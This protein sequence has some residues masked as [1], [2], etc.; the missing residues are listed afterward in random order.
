MGSFRTGYS[1]D[2]PARGGLAVDATV[3]P[4]DSAISHAEL[5][6]LGRNDAYLSDEGGEWSVW[7]LDR[8]AEAA[9]DGT[10]GLAEG[11]DPGGS[12]TFAE[13][14]GGH[15]LGQLG[16]AMPNGSLLEEEWNVIA[17][18]DDENRLLEESVS[19]GKAAFSITGPESG[20]YPENFFSWWTGYDSDLDELDSAIAPHL[21]IRLDSIP[22]V[23]PLAP[24]AVVLDEDGWENGTLNASEI[25][26][27]DGG[28]DALT[29]T[30]NGSGG[31]P[32]ENITVEI[33]RTGWINITPASNWNGIQIMEL[34]V[35]DAMGS[36]A[37]HEVAVNVVPVNDPVFWHNLTVMGSGE[38][39]DLDGTGEAPTL[40]ATEDSLFTASVNVTDVDV[41]HGG[42]IYS[43][44]TDDDL[45]MFNGVGHDVI[46]FRPNNT[47]VGYRYVT[48]EVSDADFNDTVELRV[49]VQNVN[50]PPVAVVEGHDILGGE[51]VQG[52]EVELDGGES[53]D[54]DLPHGDRLLYTWRSNR[55]GILGSDLQLVHAF[56]ETGPHS[57]S[58]TVEDAEGETSRATIE[59]TVLR[60]MDGDG[61][62]DR[63]DEDVDGDGLPDTWEE[64]WGLDPGDPT[65]A[66]GDADGDGLTN[67]QEWMNGTSPNLADTDGDGM[68]DQWEVHNGLD[69]LNPLD[70]SG[71][72]DGDGLSNLEEYLEGEDPNEA[73]VTESGSEAAGTGTST[74]FLAAIVI[75]IVIIIIVVIWMVA[76]GGRPSRIRIPM[77]RV[78]DES[79]TGEPD[80]MDD[81]PPDEEDEGGV[82]GNDDD[83]ADVKDEEVPDGKD[84]KVTDEKDDVEADVKDDEVANV[85]DDEVADV[86]DDEVPDGKDDEVPDGKDDEVADGK[87]DEVTDV[88]DARVNVGA[89]KPPSRSRR[90]RTVVKVGGKGKRRKGK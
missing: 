3:F 80:E 62:P 45:V 65:D 63:D 53:T 28:F 29:L 79:E 75:I 87:D 86:K 67:V 66:G 57:I 12:P 68:P 51:V 4:D 72:P 83:E 40:E 17:L 10:T 69:P 44:S 32:L 42:D 11:G 34:R 31:A 77:E 89:K 27:D 15:R 24:V 58:L 88:K 39:V 84:D 78:A 76:R 1:T 9:F 38:V 14:G 18:S 47:H 64:E 50:D 70:A 82:G 16:E 54:P 35:T 19:D 36:H 43:Y 30:A 73:R 20:L 48:L 74:A 90:K 49:H 46:S 7:L 33:G 37:V 56:N 23:R 26:V 59:L 8:E 13:L 61:E 5:R 60:D 25:F 22:Y 55:T 41:L 71:D 85:K 6:L 2:G 21:A 52:V 81:E